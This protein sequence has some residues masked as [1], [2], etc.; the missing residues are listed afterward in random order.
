MHRTPEPLPNFHIHNAPPMAKTVRCYF[1]Q[2]PQPEGPVVLSA[3]ATPGVLAI[4]GHGTDGEDHELDGLWVT[5]P[6]G[7]R[8]FRT[9]TGQLFRE[10]EPGAWEKCQDRRI[11]T[12]PEIGL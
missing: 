4:R 2:P 5:S 9:D 6:E 7:E 12:R 8:L 10:G 1:L 3:E 11:M